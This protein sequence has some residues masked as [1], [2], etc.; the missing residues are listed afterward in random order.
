[1]LR[2]I[3]Y[4]L[5]ILSALLLSAYFLQPLKQGKGLDKTTKYELVNNWPQLPNDLKLGNPTGI[6]IDTNQN[7]VVFHRAG[8][9][10]PLIGSMPDEPIKHK[11]ILFINKENGKL[12]ARKRP[13]TV[14]EL[15]GDQL[16][17]KSGLQQGDQLISEGFQ[18]LYDGQLLTT[19]IK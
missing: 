3:I 2:K 6:D 17:V 12:I 9:K 14:G 1:M 5:A 11:T 16:E 18:G 10:W 7:L 8:R 13:I 4:S 19:E 15:N